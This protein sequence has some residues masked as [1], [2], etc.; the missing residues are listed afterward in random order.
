MITDIICDVSGEANVPRK[1]SQLSYAGEERVPASEEPY[2]SS[3]PVYFIKKDNGGRF[4]DREGRVIALEIRSPDSAIDFE[5]KQ[6]DIV[7]KTL[8]HLTSRQ[9]K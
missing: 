8:E 4:T 7:R 9:K 5:G 3:W 1:W 6:L 2:A